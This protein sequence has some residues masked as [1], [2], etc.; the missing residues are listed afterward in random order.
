MLGRA[1]LA[2]LLLP[3]AAQAAAW[4]QRKGTWQIIS[5]VVA[6]DARRSFDGGGNAVTPALF[7]RVLLQNDIE[8]GLLSRVTIFARTET[9]YV[10]VR[11][12]SGPALTAQNNAIEG[13]LRYRLARGLGLVSDYDVL[14]LEASW[15]TAGAFNF[16]YSANADAAG[17]DYGV[18]L[19]YGSGFR[20]GGRN[21]FVNME[22]GERWLSRPRPDQTAMDLTAGLWLTPRWL[23]MLQ[24]FNLVSGPAMPPYVEF[25]THKLEVSAAY[26]LTRHLTLQAGAILSPAGRNALDERGLCLSLWADV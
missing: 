1:V 17:Q 25:R 15:R 21:G 26:R 22:I 9:A 20:L 6:S 16:A 14:S 8:Y 2:L 19:L 7:D 12:G 5:S 3:C 13:G 11:N 23:V 10:H 4:T 18:R 24:S